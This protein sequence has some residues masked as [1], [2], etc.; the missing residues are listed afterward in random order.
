MSVVKIRIALE[1]ALAAMTPAISISYENAAFQSTT[2]VPYQSPFLMV[3]TP[4]NS[5][6]GNGYYREQGIFQITLAYPIQQGT[7]PS[8]SRA[9]LI[10]QTFARGNVFANGGVN[11][12]IMKTAEI[13]QGVIDDDRWRVPVKIRWTAEIFAP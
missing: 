6:I 12:R 9:V 7:S 13:G 8:I 4:D 5:V 2:G 10:Q 3:A 11:V 1:T